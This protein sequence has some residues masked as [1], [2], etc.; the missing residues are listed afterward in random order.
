MNNELVS[1][2]LT[3]YNSERFLRKQLDSIFNQSYK[4]IEVIACDDR[5]SDGTVN[6]LEEYKNKHGLRYYVNDVN[7]GYLR[8]FEKTI[9][10]CKG[11]YIA[12]SDHDDIWMP[13][14]I[15]RLVD[16][17]GNY[18]LIFSDAFFIDNNDA[19][20]ASSIKEYA[21]ISV[22]SEKPYKYLTYKNF[23]IG[24][25]TLFK[26]EL[27]KTAIPIPEAESYHDWWLALTACTMNGLRYLPEPLV[28]YRQHE[29]NA[30]GLNKKVS[31][32]HKA[33]DFLLEKPDVKTLE[34]QEKRLEMLSQNKVFSEVE[35]RY[36][37]MA[38]GFFHDKLH[39]KVH[40]K[41]F[42]IALAYLRYISP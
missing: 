11:T 33:I 37:K 3:T 26:R 1:I 34:I 9:G 23:V 8:N 22:F 24:C 42:L 20:V 21:G 38:T 5:S 40:L 7:V 12:L 14:K 36:F 39:S 13:N 41:A 30:I 18:S 35:R 4:N 15:E 32:F 29:K 2:A 27:L 28:K 10:Y 25:T 17:I 19:V 31:L 16:Q 6:I